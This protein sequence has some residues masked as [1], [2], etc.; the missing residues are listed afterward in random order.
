[1][2]MCGNKISIEHHYHILTRLSQS[3][4]KITGVGK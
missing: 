1:M 3:V 2:F 4:F